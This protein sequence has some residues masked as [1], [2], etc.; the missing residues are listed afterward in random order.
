MDIDFFIAV[1]SQ[2]AGEKI[3]V[4]VK[5]LGFQAKVE[6]DSETGEWTCYASK[7]M[8]AD[9][10]EI[11]KTEMVLSDLAKPYGGYCDGFGSFG[12]NAQP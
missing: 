8:M 1:P 11:T 9:H 2:E 7:M 10:V 5:I 4:Q 6:V 3:A 12:N